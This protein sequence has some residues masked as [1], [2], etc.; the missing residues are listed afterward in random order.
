MSN[1]SANNVQNTHLVL[2]F[3]DIDASLRVL[4]GFL[5]TR[6]APLAGKCERK[7]I[8]CLS[9]AD[10]PLAAITAPCSKRHE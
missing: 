7:L 3:E 8:V 6:E 5:S 1:E 10:T 9:D 4:G 2:V